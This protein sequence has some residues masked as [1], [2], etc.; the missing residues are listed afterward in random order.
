MLQICQIQNSIH[1]P[2][3]HVCSKDSEMWKWHTEQN[4]IKK[5]QDRCMLVWMYVKFVGH[6]YSQYV[7]RR[8]QQNSKEKEETKYPPSLKPLWEINYPCSETFGSLSSANSRQQ[9]TKKV[10]WRRRK[11]TTKTPITANYWCSFLKNMFFHGAH[12]QASA[13]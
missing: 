8:A 7:R 4:K 12:Q 6:H 1:L 3:F 10:I 11:N 5:L 13:I 9:D 2:M